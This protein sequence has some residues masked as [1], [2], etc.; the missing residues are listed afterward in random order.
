LRRVFGDECVDEGVDEFSVV[1][2]EFVEV[3]EA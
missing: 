1:I 3:V 2:V